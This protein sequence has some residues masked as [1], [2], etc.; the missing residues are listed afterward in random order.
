MYKDNV[1]IH[2]HNAGFDSIS[3]EQIDHVPLLSAICS[4]SRV[5]DFLENYHSAHLKCEDLT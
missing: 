2:M 1:H 5:D 3:S 4:W